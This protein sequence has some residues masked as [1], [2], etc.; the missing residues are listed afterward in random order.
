MLV[1]VHNLKWTES[2]IEFEIVTSHPPYFVSID[3][4]PDEP[5]MIWQMGIAISNAI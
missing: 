5:N 2:E 4:M 1:F 3:R